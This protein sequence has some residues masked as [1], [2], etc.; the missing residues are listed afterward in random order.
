MLLLAFPLKQ[1]AFSTS[2]CLPKHSSGEQ[3]LQTPISL[4]IYPSVFQEGDSGR[5]DNM[6]KV[7]QTCNVGGEITTKG[8][9]ANSYSYQKKQDDIFQILYEEG[10]ELAYFQIFNWGQCLVKKSG[11]QNDVL[12]F[13]ISVLTGLLG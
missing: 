10:T 7:N 6:G 1:S 3:E 12:D 8:T 4:N 2:E 13:S 9:R 5:T 11:S